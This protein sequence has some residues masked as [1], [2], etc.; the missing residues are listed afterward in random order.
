MIVYESLEVKLLKENKKEIGERIHDLRIRKN[1]SMEEL[2]NNIG[3]GGK[4]TIN[5]WEKGVTL[6]RP[7]YLMRL[8]KYFGV[9]INYLK[10]GSLKNYLID[11]VIDDWD[12]ENSIIS[13]DLEH[14][15]EVATDYSGF[16]NGFPLSV[17]D[18]KL[19]DFYHEGE[20]SF[21]RNAINSNYS[22]IANFL[23]STLKYENDIEILKELRKW[24]RASANRVGSSFLGL[25]RL[26]Q[27]GIEKWMP[28]TMGY[29]DKTVKDVKNDK[30][31]FMAQW[32]DKQILD[33]IY[34][35]KLVDWQ[36]DALDKLSQLKQEYLKEL[37]KIEDNDKN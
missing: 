27:D 30:S 28:N 2:A 34:Q 17:P 25:T 36:L 16:K 3:V 9:D 14:Y 10:Y 12:K 37:Q 6:P 11:L 5:T 23:G 21:I 7:N 13:A 4:S 26:Y 15:L 32:P 22:E 8:S 18:E 33:S 19:G 20:L 24:L 31:D 35:S 1:L 29:S